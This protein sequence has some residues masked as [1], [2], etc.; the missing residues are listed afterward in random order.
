MISFHH[1]FSTRIFL[2]ENKSVE[3]EARRAQAAA[4]LARA[5]DEARTPNELREFWWF[6]RAGQ[7]ANKSLE[8][9]TPARPRSGG[10][11]T[12]RSKG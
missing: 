10:R 12:L 6:L 5:K 8:G 3:R 9:G 11:P 7:G 2:D 4:A 1:S